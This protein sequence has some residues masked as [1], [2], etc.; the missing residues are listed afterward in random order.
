MKSAEAYR[1]YLQ[2]EHW[3]VLRSS[4]LDR[5]GHKCRKCGSGKFLQ[6][7]HRIY[8]TLWTETIADDLVTLCNDCHEREHDIHLNPRLNSIGMKVMNGIRLTHQERGFLYETKRS[9]DLHEVNRAI[10]L[11]EMDS[12]NFPAV[13]CVKP[14]SLLPLNMVYG[15]P[16]KW[17]KRFRSYE[18]LMARGRL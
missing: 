7:H 4:V 16:K 12:K 1:E 9:S 18:N 2:T 6:V 11:L 5:D 17:L 14:S 3:R 10:R 15:K 13:Y 8:R